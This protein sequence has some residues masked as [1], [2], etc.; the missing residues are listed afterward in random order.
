MQTEESSLL[1][2][3]ASALAG[4]GTEHP[5]LVEGIVQVEEGPSPGDGTLSATLFCDN[6]D[7]GPVNPDDIPRLIAD[8]AN[9]V[10]VDLDDYQESQLHRLGELLRLNRHA[11]DLSLS[12]WQRPQLVA[13]PNHFFVSV[14]VPHI[15]RN[16]EGLRVSE[17]DLY[18]GHNFLLS[19][20]KRSLPFVDR[21]MSR[22]VHNPGVVEHDA[23]FMLYIILDE[24][25]DYCDHLREA[26]RNDIEEA[27]ERAF[28]DTS[29]GFLRELLYLKRYSAAL[30]FLVDQHRVVFSAFLR[31]DF[32]WLQDAT[33][34]AYFRDLEGHLMYLTG[35]L[36]AL[37]DSVLG[38]FDIYFSQVT[39][40]TNGVM[41]VLTMV[42]TILFP[43]T[44]IIGIF[45][46]SF[47][48]LPIYT[49]QWFVVMLVCIVAVSAGILWTY[50][51]RGWI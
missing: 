10:W 46:T 5:S 33:M 35:S 29:E 47:K 20:H 14:T 13:Y 22:A 41:K 40:R 7:R 8:D 4:G 50:H 42:S 19:A 12:S 3:E 18:V 30:S 43:I 16:E 2:E 31:P 27:E 51:R 34:E 9:F 49:A 15:D 11:I 23:A 25:L 21:I 44:A 28:E 45:G 24:L 37:R 36:A 32:T 39:H 26:L 38:A 17:L 1:E 6:N 48:G